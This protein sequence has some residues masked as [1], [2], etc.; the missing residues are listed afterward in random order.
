MK[1]YPDSKKIFF[2]VGLFTF[3]TIVALFL[4]Y[5]WMTQLLSSH[6]YQ[7]IL[8]KFPYA[9]GL[10]KGAKVCVLGVPRG[11]ISDIVIA[12]DGVIFSLKVNIPIE[13]LANTQFFIEDI[14]LMGNKQVN[15]IPSKNG[16]PLD[17]D[18]IQNGQV[19]ITL[20][21]FIVKLDKILDKLSLD[22]LDFSGTQK[23]IEEISLLSKNANLAFHK[24]NKN[25]GILDETKLMSNQINKIL[26]N[27]SST[28]GNLTKFIND[29][30]LYNNL[31]TSSKRA[32]SILIDI[33]ENPT[34]YFK[35]KIF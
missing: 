29:S 3:V 17:L 35:I 25:Q 14:D 23:L 28:N 30:T 7:T 18:I 15:I 13:L 5:G 2:Q 22:S 4:S 31:V 19:K 34:R 6:K 26:E 8:V 10:N 1:Y 27:L 21:R 20:N 33:R 11:K 32:D 16:Y 24:L 12:Q 9:S